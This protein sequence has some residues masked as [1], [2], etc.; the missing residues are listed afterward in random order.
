MN[1][2]QTKLHNKIL[3]SLLFILIGLIEQ[4]IISM[5]KILTPKKT[6]LR[7]IQKKTKPYRRD[8]PSYLQWLTFAHDD[9][10]AAKRLVQHEQLPLINPAL[11][12]AQQAAEKTLKSYLVFRNDKRTILTHHLPKL[13][14][15]CSIYD[16]SFNHLV[17]DALKLNPHTHIS[18]YPSQHHGNTTLDNAKTIVKSAHDI[19]F[20]VFNKIKQQRTSI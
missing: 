4:N 20:F 16:R 5:A 19:Y 14:E 17:H 6:T 13:V 10:I 3:W 12:L 1:G 18:R 2:F 8:M 15:E 9:L 11:V 7:T